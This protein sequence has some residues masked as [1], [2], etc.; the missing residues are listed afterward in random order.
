MSTLLVLKQVPP[1]V[2]HGPLPAS[3]K[4]TKPGVVTYPPGGVVQLTFRNTAFPILLNEVMV[5]TRSGLGSSESEIEI[6]FALVSNATLN[7]V[8]SA[9]SPSP[10][11]RVKGLPAASVMLVVE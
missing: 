10:T 6:V 3:I 8:S 4:L 5:P 9:S 11:G 1:P 2:A 7:D